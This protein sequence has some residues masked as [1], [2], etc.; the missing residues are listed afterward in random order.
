MEIEFDPDKNLK[1]INERNISFELAIK[2]DFESAFIWQ[3]VRHIYTESRFCALGYI[4]NRLYSLVFTP[5]MQVM[6]IIS[7]RK[8]NQREVK[9]YD[10]EKYARNS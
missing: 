9:L 7:L 10:K 1:N 2:F 8:A 5:R 4:N 3:D 6:R